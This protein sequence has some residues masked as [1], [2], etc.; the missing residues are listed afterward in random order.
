VYQDNYNTGHANGDGFAAWNWADN[1]MTQTV[2]YESWDGSMVVQHEGTFTNSGTA[3]VTVRCGSHWDIALSG[4]TS[5]NAKDYTISVDVKSVA[6]EWD[7]ITLELW[8]LPGNVGHGTS[9]SIAQA[10]GWVTKKYNLADLTENWWNGTAWDLTAATWSLE[11]GGTPWPGTAVLPGGSVDVMWL[12]DNV[13]IT[14]V[15]EPAS[16]ILL[17][18]GSLAM[19][20]KRK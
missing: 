3:A 15:P 17:G 19:L 7:P 2:T 16:L 1:G 9:M 4:N 13:K 14:M 6:G 5:A 18:L 10:D 20:R 8:A 11:L 12:M